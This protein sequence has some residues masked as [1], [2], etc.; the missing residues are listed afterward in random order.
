MSASKAVGFARA[1]GPSL[2][3]GALLL[4]A[5]Y[6][7]H[8]AATRPDRIALQY[9]AHRL[10]YGALDRACDAMV[11]VLD[12]YGVGQDGRFAIMAKNSEMF[13]VALIAAARAGAVVVP[14]NWRNTAAETRYVIADSEVTLA[15]AE[16][17]FVP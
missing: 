8:F 15:I 16:R 3:A 1:V 9:G 4:P 11:A 7:S 14:I 2:G 12:E 6:P 13:F 10:T 5:D 17:E